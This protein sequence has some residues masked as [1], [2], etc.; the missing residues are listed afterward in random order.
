MGKLDWQDDG[1]LQ[2]FLGHLESRDVVPTDV[3]L[4]DEDRARETCAQL[5]HFGILVTVVVILPETTPRIVTSS[6]CTT[7]SAD[8]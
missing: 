8:G 1:L 3:G 2:R 7:Q 5:F 6:F 4:V